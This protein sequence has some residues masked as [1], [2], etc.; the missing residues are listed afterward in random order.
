MQLFTILGYVCNCLRSTGCLPILKAFVSDVIKLEHGPNLVE[1]VKFGLVST[2]E[3]DNQKI[4]EVSESSDLGEQF[5]ETF[6]NAS[7]NADLLA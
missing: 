4:E 2:D 6:D 5:G 7:L 1:V 3:E